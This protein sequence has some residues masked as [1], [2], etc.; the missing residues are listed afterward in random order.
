MI[1]QIVIIALLITTIFS[2]GNNR[3]DKYAK[4]SENNITD[5]I[6]DKGIKLNDEVDSSLFQLSSFFSE[7]SKNSTIEILT[8]SKKIDRSLSIDRSSKKSKL[9]LLQ[10]S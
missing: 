6:S 10:P 3:Q 4:I 7:S 9:C 1:G 8:S 2:C 5:T